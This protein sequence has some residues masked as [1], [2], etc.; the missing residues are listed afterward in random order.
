MRFVSSF[1]KSVSYYYGDKIS[2]GLY[3]PQFKEIICDSSKKKNYLCPQPEHNIWV[4]TTLIAKKFTTPKLQCSST[5]TFY[6]DT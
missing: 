3:Q 6:I 2:P 5:H 1:Q 4:L